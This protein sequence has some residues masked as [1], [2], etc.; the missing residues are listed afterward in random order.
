MLAD[1][2]LSVN[3]AADSR[4]L[5]FDLKKR[6]P[7][8]LNISAK[9]ATLLIGTEPDRARMEI[10]QILNADAKNPTGLLLQG[11]LQ[12]NAG[13]YDLAAATLEKEPQVTAAFPQASFILGEISLKKGQMDQAQSHFQKAI[14]VNGAYLPARVGLAEVYL[15]KGHTADART[16]VN[17][18]LSVQKGFIPALLL[19]TNIDVAEKKYAEADQ[20]FA[21]LVKE[22]PNNGLIHMQMGM[23]QDSRGRT[24]DAEKN[25]LR[26][27]ELQPDSREFLQGLTTF[28]IRTKQ[29]DKALQKIKSI[30]DEKKQAFHYEM[31]GAVYVQAGKLQESEEAFKKAIE[32]DPTGTNAE[33]LLASLY[34]Q[35]QRFDEGM[36]QID[37]I[38]KK[39]PSNAGAIAVKGMIYENQGKVEEAKQSYTQALNVDPN[40]ETAAN[41]LAFILAEQGK[42][43]TTAL[44]WAQMARRKQPEN[45]NTADTLGWVY[46]KLGNTLLAK[47]Q[48]L[49][50]V[51]KQPDMGVFQYHLGMIY[52]QNKQNPEAQAALKKAAASPKDFKE[53]PLAQ[54]ALKEIAELK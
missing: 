44:S 30:P 10:D 35:T 43:L 1:L 7:K 52:K 37:E 48:L 41:N 31:L 4:A 50:A 3:R 22:Q 47:D 19:K 13:Q 6:F 33:G 38:L 32:K 5:L 39:N 20:G 25:M 2:Y 49:F 14:D 46:Y 34:I 12:F 54:A 16:E 28:Y 9:I 24:A 8:D 26:A 21:D 18:I 11:E 29:T 23:Y 27:L 17:K 53:K 45:P 42:D 15:N 51:G 36:K 40:N